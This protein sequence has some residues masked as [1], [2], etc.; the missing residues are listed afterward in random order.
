MILSLVNKKLEAFQRLIQN[1]VCTTQD[2]LLDLDEAMELSRAFLSQVKEQGKHLYAIG[3]GPSGSIASQFC[4]QLMKGPQIA[5]M[6]LF[7]AQSLTATA[8]ESG[9]AEVFRQ[10]LKTLLKGGDLLLAV[11]TR[12]K[13][14]NILNAVE[15]AQ[16]KGSLLI[17][18]SGFESSNPLREAG[19]LN[20]WIDSQDESLVD[21]VH[22]FLLHMILETLTNEKIY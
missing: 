15:E 1:C 10:P 18:L 21:L 20:F 7:D 19:D 14:S 3:N 22:H 6:P 12:G 16:N 4:S 8:Y 5:A 13:S 17:T 2:D 11:S 9:Y